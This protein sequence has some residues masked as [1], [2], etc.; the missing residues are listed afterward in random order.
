MPR[1]IWEKSNYSDTLTKR[2]FDVGKIKIELEEA[3]EKLDM[4]IEVGSQHLN[5]GVPSPPGVQG[6]SLV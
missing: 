4:I 1:T 5:C 2:R 6:K 3:N